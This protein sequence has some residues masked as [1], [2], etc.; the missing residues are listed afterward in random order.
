MK[1]LWL[2]L[3]LA[4]AACDDPREA[5]P[6]ELTI[7]VQGDRRELE[8]QDKSLHER[9]EALQKEKSQLDAR[10]AE[11]ARG[12]KAAADA[13]QKARLEE[14]LRR[15]QALEGQ[16]NVRASALQAQKSEFEAKRQAIDADAQK[17]A[18]AALLARQAAVVAREAKVAEREGQIAQMLK[19]LDGR[20]K[21]ISVRE[22]DV[23]L[24]E[25][26]VSA[27]ER[28]GPPPEY[29]DPKS[30]P[31]AAAIEKRHKDLLADLDARGILISDLPPENQP[32]NANIFVAKRQGDF[33]RAWDLIGQLSKV[34]AKLKV[35][36]KFVEQ[37][38]VRLQGARGSAK[39][40]DEQ[41]TAV[42]KLLR[43]VTAAFSD[44]HYDT[45]NKGLNRIAVILDANAA[46]G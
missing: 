46:S 36:Q 40:S 13:Q 29:R 24:R 42:E 9:E 16:I 37:K 4:A 26:A 35:D 28:Q 2:A 30:V 6:D 3:V 20:G 22:K 14:E 15:Q 8:Q 18:Q 1:R 32:L 33:A 44:G 10:I 5:V 39:L 23:A 34:V 45:A 38:M 17:A 21:D 27:F 31:K 25:K 11:L 19:E 41:R 7:V 43:E 12:L